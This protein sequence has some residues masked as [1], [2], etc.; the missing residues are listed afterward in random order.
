M[1]N[2]EFTK[3]EI[4]GNMSLEK[5][6]NKY[7]SDTWQYC[8]ELVRK[9]EVSS[10]SV[11]DILGFEP[12]MGAGVFLPNIKCVPIPALFPLYDTVTVG[13]PKVEKMSQIQNKI[14]LTLNDIVTL[15][16][17]KKLTLH[18]NVDCVDCQKKMASV[19]QQ[20]IDSDVPFFLSGPQEW[21]LEL[22]AAETAGIDVKHGLEIEEELSRLVEDQATKELRKK[23]QE[24]AK[25]LHQ[26][27]PR[28]VQSNTTVR[29]CSMIDPTAEYLQ[30]VIDVGKKGRPPE[31]LMA[32]VG[33]LYMIPK[34]LLAKAFDSILS[35]NANCGH[36]YEI[37]KDFNKSFPKLKTREHF[38]PTKLEFIEKKLH[39]AY[40]EDIPLIEYA[41]IFDS[42]ATNAIRKI[43]RTIISE[44]ASKKTSFVTLQNSVDDYNKEVSEMLSRRTKRAKIVYATS[45]IL[46]SNANAIKMLLGGVAEKYLNAP[47]KAWDCAVLPTRY[48]RDV[49][50]WLQQK[51]TWIESKLMGV[52][53]DVIHLYRVR[54]CLEKLR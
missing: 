28:I 47:Q 1:N 23:L 34:F 52:S 49:S 43:V 19:I 25:R 4:F 50:S 16:H 45:D 5:K 30:E 44:A 6:G 27:P 37:E 14:G 20:F 31:Y 2:W 29:T 22:K 36:L 32:L 40:S 18:V 24:H 12:P 51:T 42:S 33:R 21:L 38:D 15:A 3:G 17:K 8:S 53:P 26:T 46:K 11:K 35:T 13:I 39:I 7:V 9:S 41:D 54:T 48:R 10:L